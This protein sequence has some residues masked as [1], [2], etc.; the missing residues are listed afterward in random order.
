MQ[1]EDLIH[2]LPLPVDLEEREQIDAN[3]ARLQLHVL[4]YNLGNF[5]TQ[6]NKRGG[7]CDVN[8]SPLPS[9][10]DSQPIRKSRPCKQLR[11][12][13]IAC[14]QPPAGFLAQ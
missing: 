3:Q 5:L 7:V 14:R 11:S 8:L 13:W 1:V 4:A 9:C 10:F 12:S 6:P 2:D